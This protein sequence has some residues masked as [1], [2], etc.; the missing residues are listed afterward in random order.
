MCGSVCG[1]EEKDGREMMRN[2][3]FSE[4]LFCG[5][6]RRTEE[7]TGGEQQRTVCVLQGRRVQLLKA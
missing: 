2:K 3:R 5:S 6:N 4:L 7:A 1:Q